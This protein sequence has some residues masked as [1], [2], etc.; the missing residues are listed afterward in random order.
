M[1]KGIFII[2]IALLISAVVTAQDKD[3]TQLQTHDVSEKYT[4]P[5]RDNGTRTDGI[6]K[7]TNRVS[8]FLP[9]AQFIRV[10]CH[11]RL[12]M[13]ITRPL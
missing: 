1:K 7:I 13:D 2:V 10:A 8:G 4:I 12:L 5:E 9:D 11:V 3:Q 6:P